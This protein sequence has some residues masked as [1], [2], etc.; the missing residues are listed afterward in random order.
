MSGSSSVCLIGQMIVDYTVGN[1]DEESKLRLGG[2]AHAA[3]MAWAM[4]R[5]YS[6]C[7]FAPEYLE[8]AIGIFSSEMGNPKTTKIGNVLGSP[9]IIV[10]SA[11]REEGNQGY[12]FLL[13]GEQE[14]ITDVPVLER[15][16]ALTPSSDYLIFPGSFDLMAVLAVL[17]KTAASVHIDLNFQPKD[18]HELDSL[19]RPLNTAIISTSSKLFLE[20]FGGSPDATVRALLPRHS[21][22]VLFK[23]NRGGSRY[24][25]ALSP[26]APVYIPSFTRPAEHS[27][28]VGDC[29][30]VAY[31]LTR[32]QFD[33]QTSLHY[34]A[35]AAAEYAS[36]TFPLVLKEQIENVF[37]ILP[38]EAAELSGVILPWETRQKV[39]VYVAAP[40]FDDVRRPPIERVVECL[41]YHNF[42][43]RRPVR[44]NG[45]V[46]L[47]DG[48]EKRTVLCDAD[49]RLLD[50]CQMVVAV[51]TEDDPGTLIEIGIAVERGLPVVVFDP[52]DRARNLM[53][54]QLPTLVSS[55]LDAVI[56]EVFV[57][58]SR[59]R[60]GEYGRT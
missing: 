50:E 14:T 1:E 19:G 24:F 35:L 53:L 44:E 21:K 34:S 30:N 18:L 4:N 49:L 38:S 40:D 10:I 32:E 3:R 48:P 23:E 15:F 58:A 51:L 26:S 56:S 6:M 60:A 45:Q 39:N 54:T 11:P 27:V 41:Q 17:A 13:R 46:E 5:P 22:A 9:N 31:V 43:P 37:A 42:H 47:A 36:T 59:I 8:K 55:S 2:I 28:G 16:I 20:Q 52:Y 7:Y 12:D 25:S 33:L 57:Q 29:Y